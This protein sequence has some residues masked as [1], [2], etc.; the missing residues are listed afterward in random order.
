MINFVSRAPNIGKEKD[1]HLMMFVF[2]IKFMRGLV[3]QTDAFEDVIHSFSVVSWV[4][5]F[6][7]FF[8]SEA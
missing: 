1:K 2:F 8:L 6:I 4:E 7:D 3:T 5:D